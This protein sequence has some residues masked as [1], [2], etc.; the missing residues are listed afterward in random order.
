MQAANQIIRKMLIMTLG[1]YKSRE[2]RILNSK[3]VRN[4][5]CMDGVNNG[6]T[7]KKGEWKSKTC[8]T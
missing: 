3:G 5:I 7:I 1:C 8:C 4:D 2:D 6:M